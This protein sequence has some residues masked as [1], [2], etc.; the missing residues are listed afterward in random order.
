MKT[1]PRAVSYLAV[2]VV[3]A[4]AGAAAV[5][6]F[7][8]VAWR[9]GAREVYRARPGEVL[10]WRAGTCDVILSAAGPEVPHSQV[11]MDLQESSGSRT[12]TVDYY[13]DHLRVANFLKGNASA[14]R[15]NVL[16]VDAD[17]SGV[18]HEKAVFDGND[19]MAFGRSLFVLT[20]AT[21]SE[22]PRDIWS[23]KSPSSP[24][25]TEQ[26]WLDGII[27]RVRERQAQGGGAR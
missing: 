4:L 16:F 24:M 18:P 23:A 21:W 27:R 26:A 15:H 5:C 3:G 19:H 22:V 14:A 1:L 12:L 13:S 8:R 25:D 17:G 9:Q 11:E 6:V 2:A 10:V 20:D 7:G